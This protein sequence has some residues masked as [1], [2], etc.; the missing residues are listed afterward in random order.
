MTKYRSSNL[1]D[2]KWDFPVKKKLKIC[3]AALTTMVSATQQIRLP[4]L[5]AMCG[6]TKIRYLLIELDGYPELQQNKRNCQVRQRDSRREKCQNVV[7]K[8]QLSTGLKQRPDV[9]SNL[10]QCRHNRINSK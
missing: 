9:P 2:N 6:A 7:D 10:V 1:D 5:Y 3:L 4:L 8:R